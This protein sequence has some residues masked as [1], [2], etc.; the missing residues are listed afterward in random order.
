MADMQ[1][2]EQFLD[3]SPWLD[4]SLPTERERS[5]R[6]QASTMDEIN[7]FYSAMLPRMEAVLAYL[8]AYPVDDVDADVETLLNLTLSLAEVAPAVENFGQPSVVDGY[9]VTRFVALHD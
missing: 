8:S 5:A 4:C 2:P 9:D 1:L 7:A 6:R 3:L